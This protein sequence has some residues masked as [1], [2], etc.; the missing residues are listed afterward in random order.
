MITSKRLLV[1]PVIA[2]LAG[3][4]MQ[5]CGNGGTANSGGSGGSSNV[6]GT[7]GSSGTGGTPA[8]TTPKVTIVGSG[9]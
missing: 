8:S 4:V 2:L 3:G 5:G 7:G 1:A 9:S 6:S